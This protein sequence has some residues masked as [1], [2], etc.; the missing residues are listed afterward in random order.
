MEHAGGELGGEVVKRA[1]EGELLLM[2]EDGVNALSISV[3]AGARVTYTV[4][5]PLVI[6]L[7]DSMGTRKEERKP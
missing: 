3:P 1:D 6:A 7:G 5:A 4:P 2:G